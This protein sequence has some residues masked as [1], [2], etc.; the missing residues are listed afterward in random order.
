MHRD[1]RPHCD[2]P[3]GRAGADTPARPRVP[4]W[5]CAA[6]S[7]LC[8]SAQPGEAQALWDDRLELFAAQ[9][10]THD[11]N[12]FRL[13]GASD[14]V[15]T[16]G[17]PEKGDRILTTTLGL[18][19]DAPLGRQRLVGNFSWIR[20]RYEHFTVLD[21]DGYNGRAA[22]QWQA[23]N[24]WSGRIGY[25]QSL[26]LASLA[27]MQEGVQSSTPNPLTQRRAV[28]EAAWRAA[29][30]WELRGETAQLRQDNEAAE[31]TVNDIV[32][33][34]V[35][36]I[37]NYVTPAQNRLGL[38]FQGARGMLP[39]PELASGMLV[40]NSYRQERA[41]AVLEWTPSGHL[42]IDARAGWVSRSYADLPQRN[43]SDGTYGLTLRWTPTGKLEL[44]LVVQNDISATEQ[45]NVS[46]VMARRV[47]LYPVW[48][49]SEK[50]ALRAVAENSNR[51]YHGE[52]GQVLGTV[53]P[54]SERVRAVGLAFAYRPLRALTLDL[55]WRRETRAATVP[56]SD[57]DADIASLS[58]RIA[59]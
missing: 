28:L 41:G 39:N 18:N 40:D 11:D 43:F 50:S 23:G 5:L 22:L 14:P 16:L 54:R 4:R 52:A 49:L 34:S 1:R 53:P 57:Y 10:V 24:D 48:Q 20:T 8:L 13:S 19:L 38:Y 55:S 42:R 3:W 46:L 44:P 33:D 2:A 21:L 58:A 59:F 56:G 51:S 45:V 30:R 31:R 29:A 9:S 17:T 6:A 32:L 35:E 12:V 36:L 15:A 37:L 26:A 25:E 47:G 7:A 27:N